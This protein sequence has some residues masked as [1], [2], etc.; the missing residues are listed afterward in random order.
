MRMV[1]Y[2]A[3]VML[4]MFLQSSQLYNTVVSRLEEG[5]LEIQL[6]VNSCKEAARIREG[7]NLTP[8]IITH[9]VSIVVINVKNSCILFFFS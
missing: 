7:M 1:V 2:V 3:R 8:K 6:M 4:T 9:K 5:P